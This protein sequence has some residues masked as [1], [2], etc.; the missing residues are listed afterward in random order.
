MTEILT[1]LKFLLWC[2]HWLPLLFVSLLWHKVLC[3]PYIWY[4]FIYVFRNGQVRL[5]SKLN[6][7]MT[8]VSNMILLSDIHEANPLA[9]HRLMDDLWLDATYVLVCML[10]YI[11]NF[12]LVAM[13]VTSLHWRQLELT[14]LPWKLNAMSL[15]SPVVVTFFHNG[16][17]YA[18]FSLIHYALILLPPLI[19]VYAHDLYQQPVLPLHTIRILSKNTFLVDFPCPK[20]K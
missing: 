1:K 10:F 20:S 13:I 16:N 17:Q 5:M 2:W 14:L 12:Y 11:A 8:S 18:P 3:H 4:R 9:Y 15:R 19:C 6:F 7:H